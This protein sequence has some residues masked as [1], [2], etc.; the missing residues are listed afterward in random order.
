MKDI[1]MILMLQDPMGNKSRFVATSKNT[2]ISYRLTS[3]AAGWPE[4][5]SNLQIAKSKYLPIF[6]DE[7]DSFDE[8]ASEIKTAVLSG[9]RS[10]IEVK[11]CKEV[12]NG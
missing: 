1:K 9:V 10:L 12:D 2:E 6:T 4:S 3:L 8:L 11:M 7:Y 5:L